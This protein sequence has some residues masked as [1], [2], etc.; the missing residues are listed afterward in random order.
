LDWKSCTEA[1]TIR[2][3][4]THLSS[5]LHAFVPKI[6]TGNLEYK[7]E[8]WPDDYEGNLSY[9]LKKIMGDIEAGK[10]KLM[11]SLDEVTDES[12]A[13][14]ID[15]F[16]GKQPRQAYL[17]LAISEIMHHEGQIA[18]ILGVEKR[19]KGT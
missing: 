11:K 7:P 18:A 14:E 16:F 12:L 3:C 9:S 17:L 10:D 8:G 5:E 19:M 15:W 13:E 6:L 1:N 2:W 4:L